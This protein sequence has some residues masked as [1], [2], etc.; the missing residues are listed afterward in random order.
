MSD[1]YDSFI[2]TLQRDTR[3]DDAEPTIAAIRQI[4]GVL[5]VKPH[6][7]D[8]ATHVA[9]ERAKRELLDALLKVVVP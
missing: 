6:V 4:R 8:I 1:R 2:V 3:D 9:T 7:S 5:S